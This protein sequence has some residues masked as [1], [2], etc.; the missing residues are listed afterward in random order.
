[1]KIC[2]AGTGAM[3]VIHAKALAKIDGVEIVSIASRAEESGKKFA[4]EYKI[5]FTSTSLE[6]C[7]DRPGVDAVIL[8]TPSDQ[9]HDQTIMALLKGKHVQVEIPMALNLKDS[10][11]MLATAKKAGKVCMV[12]H[13]RRFSAPH[14]EIK[15]R[16]REG[17]FHL[18]HLVVETYFFRRTN[19]NMH[20]QARSWGGILSTAGGL[21]FF[22]ND[23]GDFSA[24]DAATGKVLWGFPANQLWKASPMTYTHNGRQYVSTAAGSNVVTFALK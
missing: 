22:G 24:A 18:H 12:T 5:P 11:H 16:I 19:L 15:K 4:E 8:T 2:L 6:A 14:R 10:E 17:T 13:T 7:I 9:H 3:G 21:L 20:G 23:N 1:M